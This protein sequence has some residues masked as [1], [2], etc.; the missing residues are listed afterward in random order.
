MKHIARY[1]IEIGDLALKE[2]LKKR[3]FPSSLIKKCFL[4]VLHFEAQLNTFLESVG[5]KFHDQIF[6]GDLKV[7][8]TDL[9]SIKWMN[10][11][12]VDDYLTRFR[13]MGSRCFTPIP[14]VEIVKIAAGG[15]DYYT[16]K[17]LVNQ[18][19]IDLAQLGDKVR[20][21]EQ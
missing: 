11:E 9:F 15:L 2:G 4:L 19:I 21:I 17:K 7:G 5:E 1:T 13:Q 6:K 3:F 14:E 8:L 16:E 18:H 20:Q 12:S 10:N